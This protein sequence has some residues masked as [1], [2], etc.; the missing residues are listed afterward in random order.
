VNVSVLEYENSVT[1]E[2]LMRN[3]KTFEGL[4]DRTFFYIRGL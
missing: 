1:F 3:F 2:T 4:N